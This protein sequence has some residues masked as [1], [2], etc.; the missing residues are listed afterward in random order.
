MSEESRIDRL[1]QL[2]ALP[3]ERIVVS[4]CCSA[5]S[6]ALGIVGGADKKFAAAQALAGHRLLAFGV[7]HGQP[8]V[9]ESRLVVK[10]K[11]LSELTEELCGVLPKV[12]GPIV[13]L[14]VGLD[15]AAGTDYDAGRFC[16]FPWLNQRVANAL[17]N[18]PSSGYLFI[19]GGPM[20]GKTSWALN[21]VRASRGLAA[22]TPSGVEGAVLPPLSAWFFARRYGIGG[23][24]NN[25]YLR[26]E[27]ALQTL[28]SMARLRRRVPPANDKSPLLLDRLGDL[29]DFTKVPHQDA[30]GSAFQNV[31]EELANAE[32]QPTKDQPLILLLDGGDELWGVGENTLNGRR[33][34]PRILPDTLPEHV[35]IVLLSRPGV[36]LLGQHRIKPVLHYEFTAA[37]AE[38][39]IDDYLESQANVFDKLFD[40]TEGDALRHPDFKRQIAQASEG[41]FGYV[42][43][44]MDELLKLGPKKRLEQLERWRKEPGSLPFG[45][46]QQRARELFAV[47]EVLKSL[48]PD[49]LL[50]ERLHRL[51]VQ[52]LA[53]L[54]LLP[55]PLLTAAGLADLIAEND[56]DK[57][58]LA[59]RLQTLAG[60][61]L[62]SLQSQSP[63][64]S[65]VRTA[66][67]PY[68]V[69]DHL[70][71]YELALAYWE[72]LDTPHALEGDGSEPPWRR[73]ARHAQTLRLHRSEQSPS[74]SA[75]PV[76]TSSATEEKPVL[77]LR[78]RQ[79]A[80]ARLHRRLAERSA[81]YWPRPTTRRP[82]TQEMIKEWS[83][84][85]RYALLWGSWHAFKSAEGRGAE[86]EVVD[87]SPAVRRALD[88]L[89]D[90]GYLQTVVRIGGENSLAA[91]IEMYTAA[92][93]QNDA[94]TNRELRYSIKNM[95]LS[96]HSKLIA[97]QL[98]V[99]ALLWNL[100]GGWVPAIAYAKNWRE[101]LDTP[102]LLV[103]IPYTSVHSRE[104]LE[105][106]DTY[107]L[108]K[109]GQWLITITHDEKKSILI[110][111]D[112]SQDLPR[113]HQS[114]C[115]V[116]LTSSLDHLCCIMKKNSLFFSGVNLEGIIYIG[117]ID[118]TLG[119]S[120]GIFLYKQ[121]KEISCL[122]LDYEN[123][124]IIIAIGSK[125]GLVGLTR[126]SIDI[127]SKEQDSFNLISAR[128][129]YFKCANH[130]IHSLVL[131]HRKH[132]VLLVINS[133][134]ALT[135]LRLDYS[136]TKKIKHTLAILT[137][138][139]YESGA[140]YVFLTASDIEDDNSIIFCVLYC[141]RS[142][143]KLSIFDIKNELV[144][145]NLEK[146][147]E[148]EIVSM[149]L[150]D[151]IINIDTENLIEGPTC[152]AIKSSCDKF[153][154]SIGTEHG[155][156]WVLY[157]DRCQ[158]TNGMIDPYKKFQYHLND[159]GVNFIGIYGDAI[160]FLVAS[161]DSH[162]IVLKKI[163]HNQ[164]AADDI[165]C[166]SSRPQ[167]QNKSFFGFEREFLSSEG[168]IDTEKYSVTSYGDDFNISKFDLAI[169]HNDDSFLE[170]ELI[171]RGI[172]E[173]SPWF[174]LLKH[175]SGS[176][177]K[178]ISWGYIPKLD[179]RPEDFTWCLT[180]EVVYIGRYIK[181]KSN[182]S[183]DFIIDIICPFKTKG[184]E[185]YIVIF[186][187]DHETLFIID[188]YKSTYIELKY[189]NY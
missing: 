1:E 28:I 82:A 81:R 76:A 124:C 4:A 104:R 18:G 183:S 66:V 185:P 115:L 155:D 154:V 129:D 149:E 49:E 14:P 99:G 135:A 127:Y 47:G 144:E 25:P 72:L 173:L 161:L 74:T 91:I 119:R 8:G 172:L 68:L 111:W 41:A 157:I 109:C 73:I 62:V 96:W 34:F 101:S 143:S 48:S 136:N 103:N 55:E 75:E 128:W 86:Y 150:P 21:W 180:K 113:Q 11:T 46:Y 156:C 69:L 179:S 6:D 110:V 163:N 83:D 166:L 178:Y 168:Y 15:G 95:L 52:A 122:T 130:S 140:F 43:R 174:N 169:F 125:D 105:D 65:E 35:F 117:F 97:N 26:E 182:Q 37:D 126:L 141:T 112:L 87:P 147:L 181:E 50:T 108:T 94:E 116:N 93:Q 165:K 19:I 70:L 60:Q 139:Y 31:L 22:S 64:P 57:Q 121:K 54:A 88:L 27:N 132:D 148:K 59:T 177:Y 134:R 189:I 175:N 152:I 13:D 7:A 56:S 142:R 58:A 102:A 71:T 158:A 30:L 53:A 153:I 138:K 44:L 131:R 78:Q 171:I 84:S 186:L 114:A 170:K 42:T 89:L 33:V 16:P 106:Y 176:S 3:L 29:Y 107:A 63:T 133:R 90:A 38:Q 120:D 162:G 145:K 151:S 118:L 164:L 92:D 10:G 100:L 45:V 24:I 36:H 67:L 80:D 167:N 51:F 77:T 85:Q 2:A 123:D 184:F 61:F 137:R 146:K 12:Y 188:K 9:P 79:S 39:A 160:S 187:N 23:S 5:Q 98:S 40:K 32:P 159:D 17:K 20:R